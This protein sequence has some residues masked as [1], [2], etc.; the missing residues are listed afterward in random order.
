M[1]TKLN[2]TLTEVL[3][4]EPLALDRIV[5]LVTRITEQAASADAH[6]LFLLIDELDMLAEQLIGRHDQASVAEK[7][8]VQQ[9][10]NKLSPARLN[11][12]PAM[13]QEA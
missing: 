6:Q 11:N 4:T 5:G 10:V 7:A 12:P 2:Q 1:A 9:L 13:T 8:T 3:M